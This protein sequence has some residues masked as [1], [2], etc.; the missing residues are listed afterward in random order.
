MWHGSRKRQGDHPDD[1]P[2][3]TSDIVGRSG[4]ASNDKRA[5]DQSAGKRWP[6]RLHFVMVTEGTYVLH[7]ESEFLLYPREQR[8]GQLRLPHRRHRLATAWEHLALPGLHQRRR[9]LHRPLRHR[10]LAAGLPI[11]SSTT[12]WGTASGP[13]GGLQATVRHGPEV[14]DLVFIC[15]V[16]DLLRWS[17]LSCATCS[18]NAWGDDAAGFFSELTS[19]WTGSEAAYSLTGHHGAGPCMGLRSAVTA[20]R[21][22]GLRRPQIPAAAGHVCR[23]VRRAF[24]LLGAGRG[25]MPCSRLVVRPD[26]QVWMA[27]WADLLLPSVGFGTLTYASYF[28][29]RRPPGGNRPRGGLRQLP[30]SSCSR[31]SASC[32]PMAHT[33]STSDQREMKITGPPPSSFITFPTVIAQMPGG[34][35]GVLRLF[36]PWRG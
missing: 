30:P 5:C 16:I 21:Q 25:S 18:V 17:Y 3:R 35:L 34:A 6:R 8:S 22:R 9:R 1:C 32:D 26:Y 24:L 11:L 12:P 29:R 31:G 20:L 4:P 27:A 14:D 7:R 13:A 15:F 33:R 28:Q 19:G 36:L 2:V 10:A 23:F